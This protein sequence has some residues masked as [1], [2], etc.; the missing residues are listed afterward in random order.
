MTA[1]PARIAIPAALAASH[2]RYFGQAGRRWIA[3]LPNLAAEC[4]D[5]WQLR[6]DGAA[7]G[8]VV[9][10]LPVYARTGRWPL[11]SSNP[12]MRKL[13]GSR[14]PCGIGLAAARCTCMNMT[15]ARVPCCNG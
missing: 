5:R 8:A 4:M 11:S 7:A 9:L 6:P 1:G 14:S 10:V 3:E 12:S 2:D 13:V 15:G